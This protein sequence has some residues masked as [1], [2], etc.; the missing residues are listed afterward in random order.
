[1]LG[2]PALDLVLERGAAIAELGELDQVLQLQVVDVVDH[3]PP[4]CFEGTP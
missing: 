3:S 1:V 2:Q 4:S